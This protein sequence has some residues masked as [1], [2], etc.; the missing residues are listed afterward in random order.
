[1]ENTTSA[2]ITADTALSRILQRIQ[3]SSRTH[4][5]P[6]A[7]SA[8][9][10]A[11]TDIL[12]PVNVPPFHS[13]AMDGYALGIDDSSEQSTDAHD[14][15]VCEIGV[16]LAGHPFQG[17]VTQGECVRITT[18]AM[19]PDNTDRVAIVENSEKIPNEPGYLRLTR[20][21][22]ANEHV[23]HP[24]SN[25][26]QGQVLCSAG[27]KIGHAQAGLL[28]SAGMSSIEVAKPVTVAILS[29]GDELVE[30]GNPLEPGQIYDAN[31]FLL[32]SLL[33]SPNTEILDI[34][35][36][37]DSKP[38]LQRALATAES[39]DILITSGGV[40][41]GEA[42]LV[43]N[44]LSESGKMHI[45]KILM[46]PGK[47]LTFGELAS[48]TLLFGLPGNPVSSMVTYALFVVPAIRKLLGM[49]Q[50][51]LRWETAM[52]L[53]RLTKDPGRMEF[54]RGVL[55]HS[56]DGRLCVATTG[57]QDS[58]ILTSLALADCLIRL[59]L[60]SNGAKTGEPVNIVRIQDLML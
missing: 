55:S 9:R 22:I 5:V 51:E 42:D 30:P 2:A 41:V 50:R 56:P 11:A 39:A 60:E 54:Q 23:R 15:R 29:T 52:S 33:K 21:P 18:G 1:M 53:D 20:Y 31:R 47:P 10:I 40:S 16:S 38:A 3:A 25:I 58:H 43:R 44:V 27:Q 34:G 4:T 17:S 45:W 12:S 28:A 8:G 35:I 19:M 59:P 49:A 26:K 14:L 57:L 32:G 36:A 37:Q 7:E 13:S 48:G 46:K 6:V 24:G